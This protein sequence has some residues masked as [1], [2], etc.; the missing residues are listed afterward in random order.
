VRSRLTNPTSEV[1][2]A[3]EETAVKGRKRATRE[4]E[5]V[6]AVVGQNWVGVLEES[7]QNQPVVNPT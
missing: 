4:S 2:K 7:D 5:L 1:T 6:C 3:A